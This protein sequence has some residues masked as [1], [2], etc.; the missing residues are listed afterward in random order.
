MHVTIF[1]LFKKNIGLNMENA[2]L[3]SRQFLFTELATQ[4]VQSCLSVPSMHGKLSMY[5]TS[6]LG[7]NILNVPP[8]N[9]LFIS[10]HSYAYPLMDMQSSD[11]ETKFNKIA[12]FAHLAS[13]PF[14]TYAAHIHY[15]SASSAIAKGIV[16]GVHC[17]AMMI[18]TL[19][20]GCWSNT[21]T[22]RSYIDLSF[23]PSKSDLS[24]E[25]RTIINQKAERVQSIALAVSA[26][27]I[28]IVTGNP[29]MA[30]AVAYPL[31]TIVGVAAAHFFHNRSQQVVTSNQ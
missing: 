24:E 7:R 6:V 9:F 16:Y 21:M 3:P 11:F 12:S 25:G 26:I 22:L 28:N 20:P 1:F 5:V 23:D 14:I 2:S 18:L 8:L 19:A 15:L 10:H 29:I 27:A 30:N 17:T 4:F 13:I 31:A